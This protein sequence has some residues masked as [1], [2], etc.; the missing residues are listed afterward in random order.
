MVFQLDVWE[1]KFQ[2]GT[3]LHI[4]AKNGNLAVVTLLLD[5]AADVNANTVHPQR[6]RV[7]I[8][9]L[10]VQRKVRTSG[11]QSLFRLHRFAAKSESLNKKAIQMGFT[12]NHQFLTLL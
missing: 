8:S 11:C 1:E 2:D 6:I 7:S 10:K 4:A 3:A 5:R 9:Q 12:R